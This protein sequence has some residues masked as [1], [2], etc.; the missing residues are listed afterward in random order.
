[1][2]HFDYSH[3]MNPACNGRDDDGCDL[4]RAI[5]AEAEA[6]ENAGHTAL[7]AKLYEEADDAYRAM[8]DDDGEA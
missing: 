7:A 4:A 6:A 1:M 3:G 5:R 8:R 2:T